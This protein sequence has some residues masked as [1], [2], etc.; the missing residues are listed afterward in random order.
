MR[1]HKRCR[2][3]PRLAAVPLQVDDAARANTGDWFD[4]TQ[5]AALLLGEV[6]AGVHAPLRQRKS[7][8]VRGRQANNL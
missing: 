1:P 2:Q 8:E 6:G 4:S 7:F 3:H 5:N